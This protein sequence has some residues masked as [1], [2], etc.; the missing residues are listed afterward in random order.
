MSDIES[1]KIVE[2]TIIWALAV[3]AAY[4]YWLWFRRKPDA[5]MVPTT[6][7]SYRSLTAGIC[8]AFFIGVVYS[9]ML[10]A[11][12]VAVPIALG[13]F[14]LSFTGLNALNVM[15]W[16]MLL[17][18]PAAICEE[19][20]FRGFLF[21]Y[22]QTVVNLRIAL[23]LQA[24]LF[25]CLHTWG[26]DFSFPHILIT[27]IGGWVLGV[28]AFRTHTLAFCIAAHAGWNWALMG[29]V[30]SSDKGKTYYGLLKFEATNIVTLGP[31]A[32]VLSQ[33]MVTAIFLGLS[34][35]L[36]IA[37]KKVAVLRKKH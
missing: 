31:F 21:R 15:L 4:F 12:T 11:I 34:L 22:L 14:S 6:L 29:I 20:V 28:L 16:P 37:W 7:R 32:Q 18:I 8:F 30:T 2:I 24:I 9:L 13:H 26:R 23:V 35:L 17:F 36:W 1:I 3:I 27:V 10:W 5:E 33:I 25:G 19:V